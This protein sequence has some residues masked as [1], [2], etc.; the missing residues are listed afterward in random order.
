MSDYPHMSI[1]EMQEARES[2]K[3]SI[4]EA[5]LELAYLRGMMDAY[6]EIADE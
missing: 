4:Q 3:G 2:L 1:L 5:R 6:R